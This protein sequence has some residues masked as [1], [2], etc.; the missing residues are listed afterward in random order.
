MERTYSV[1]AASQSYSSLYMLSQ[2]DWFCNY[3]Q[4][5]TVQYADRIGHSDYLQCVA[6]ELFRQSPND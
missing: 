6:E 1:K 3:R 5:G 2:R 4:L